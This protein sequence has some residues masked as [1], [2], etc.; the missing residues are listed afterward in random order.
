MP[1]KRGRGRPKKIRRD[2]WGNPITER[3]T[4][5]PRASRLDHAGRLDKVLEWY[6][7]VVMRQR[8][9]RALKAEDPQAYRAA[10][11]R[12]RKDWRTPRRR[13]IVDVATLVGRKPVTVDLELRQYQR[14][15]P[16]A[17]DVPDL[18]LNEDGTL[19]KYPKEYTIAVGDVFS[20][21]GAPQTKTITIPNPFA[22]PHGRV[23]LLAN[24]NHV[25]ERAL[26]RLKRGRE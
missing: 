2:R 19:W 15:L 1:E 12:Y 25:W 21:A 5:R 23:W 14:Y 24:A 9:H 26:E 13:A 4:G 11:K 20:V 22:H 18:R 6:A 8:A 7:L 17:A 3:R 16:K 10:G